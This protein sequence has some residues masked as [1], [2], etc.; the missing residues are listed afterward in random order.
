MIRRPPRSTLFP[1]RRSSDLLQPLPPARA[2]PPLQRR[3]PHTV[4]TGR[5]G[6]PV[7]ECD[8]RTAA[9]ERELA[10]LEPRR[11]EPELATEAFA[12]DSP[13]TDLHRRD[14]AERGPDDANPSGWE[15]EPARDTLRVE[16]DR[17]PQVG[18]RGHVDRFV[19][20][21]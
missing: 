2:D 20:G 17:T 14:A 11:V 4:Q 15:A 21:A 1:T 5:Q 16:R 19:D 7:T 8:L 13:R 6:Q 12:S 3:V 18:R 10:E 9:G